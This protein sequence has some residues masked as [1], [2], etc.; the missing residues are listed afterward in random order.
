M[1][2]T[3]NPVIHS[4]MPKSME[5]LSISRFLLAPDPEAMMTTYLFVSM[6]KDRTQRVYIQQKS[7]HIGL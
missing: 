2:R 3:E 1:R 5:Q 7:R 4:F 6:R